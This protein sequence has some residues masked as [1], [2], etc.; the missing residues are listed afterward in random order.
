[1]AAKVAYPHIEKKRGQPA[2]L[3]CCNRVR[4]AQIVMDYLG[5]GMSAEEICRQYPHLRLAEVHAAM[6]CYHD[7]TEEI[8]R[9]I[10]TEVKEYEDAKLRAG[11][12]P[13]YLRMKAE[14]RI[15]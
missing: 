7:H 9:E 8:D 13:F 4:V 10:Q 5:H 6:A 12:S 3:K 11:R 1:M 14:E 15:P 2:R